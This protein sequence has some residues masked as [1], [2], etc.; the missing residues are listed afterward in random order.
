MQAMACPSDLD[1]VPDDTLSVVPRVVDR[2]KERIREDEPEGYAE[3]VRPW[4]RVKRAALLPDRPRLVA[5][6]D[7][8]RQRLVRGARVAVRVVALDASEVSRTVLSVRDTAGR[9]GAYVNSEPRN[10]MC[11]SEISSSMSVEKSCTSP[12]TRRWGERTRVGAGGLTSLGPNMLQL[13]VGSAVAWCLL[14]V[15]DSCLGTIWCDGNLCVAPRISPENGNFRRACPVALALFHV[16]RRWG[17]ARVA[18]RGWC[19]SVEW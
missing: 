9:V 6:L 11:T 7:C 5:E 16:A 15:P 4:R 19:R 12:A 3:N 10:L 17:C 8:T 14:Y 1:E 18:R 2:G 13:E